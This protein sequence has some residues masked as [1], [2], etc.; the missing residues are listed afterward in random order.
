M[1]YKDRLTYAWQVINSRLNLDNYDENLHE[2]FLLVNDLIKTL[3]PLGYRFRE[4]G[5]S[6][7]SK[8]YNKPGH[9]KSAWKMEKRRWGHSIEEYV[10][11]LVWPDGYQETQPLKDILEK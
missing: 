10:V 6:V 5:S 11:D 1:N 9:L 8:L 2:S 3:R 4:K 7:T